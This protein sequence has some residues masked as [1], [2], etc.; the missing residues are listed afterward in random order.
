[1]PAIQEPFSIRL[2][3]STFCQ[4]KCPSCPTAQ[5]ETQK[6]LGSGFLK[7]E[8]FKELVDRNPGIIHI[9][10]SNW[11]EIFLNPELTEIMK[12]AYDKGVI[13]TASNGVNLNTVK[14]Q[15]LENLVKYRFRHLD[16]S[17]DGASQ[18]TYQQYRVGGNFDRVIENIKIIN[19]YKKTYRS[20]FPL[21]LWQFV[22]FGHNEHEIQTAR[23]LAKQLDMEFYLK[24]SWDEEV[25]PIQNKELV[26]QQTSSGVASRSEY[27]ESYGTGYIRKDICQQL[28]TSPQIN[29]DGRILGCCF[30]H[31]GDFGNIFDTD[32]EQSYREKVS[33]AQ[34]MIMGKAEPRDDIPCTTCKHYKTMQAT[35]D[36]MTPNDLR[37][38]T[39]SPVIA[40]IAK[41]WGR[42]LVS[43]LNHS[44][45]L[46][47]TFLK[48][49]IVKNNKSLRE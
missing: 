34:E 13:L 43:L 27:A 48:P 24:L 31:W 21:L 49:A 14:P 45:W 47:S 9:E 39:A 36:W 12:Y 11:G 3:A 32:G 17:I 1:M 2:E 8:N 38:P 37:G 40:A 18:A 6:Q 29:W 26:R 7:F 16:C 42:S 19:H 20:D 22:A 28:V 10:L 23:E 41:R 15:V 30:N 33:Y 25:S 35:G 46:S 44:D 4:L 5:G